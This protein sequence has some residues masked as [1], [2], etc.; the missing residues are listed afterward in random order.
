MKIFYLITKPEIGGA[1]KH[2]INLAE[3]YS[4]H[5][6]VLVISGGDNNEW[7]YRKC[8]D[9]G[10]DTIRFQSLVAPIKIV[11]DMIFL[12]SLTLYLRKEKPDV[13]HC[14]SSKAGFLGRIAGF[15]SK[16]KRVV[17]TVHGVSFQAEHSRLQRSIYL[18]AEYLAYR[19]SDKIICV[20][21]F[22]SAR[23]KQYIHDKSDKVIV[24]K[25][26]AK[27]IK[28]VTPPAKMK[29]TFGFL[30][31]MSPEKDPILLLNGFALFLKRVKEPNVELRIKGGGDL[32][33]DIMS[34]ISELNLNKYVVIEPMNDVIED[35]LGRVDILTLTSKYEGYP[36]VLLE[37]KAAGCYLIAS[38]VG[39]CSEI[40]TNTEIGYLFKPGSIEH[41]TMAMESA[42]HR[43]QTK[44]KR[45]PTHH[46]SSFNEFIS[47]VESCY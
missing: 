5:H 25:N 17:F 16:T 45:I 22:D 15:L 37:G 24:I 31:R 27:P 36:Y 47:A 40:I 34:K 43:V 26:V 39:G 29:I 35:Y 14:H 7:L 23:F 2:V 32:M 6:D 9:L 42:Y 44:E 4:N 13:L 11:Q 28:I 10:I 38:D 33:A 20:S 46:S 1:T 12:V 30:G 41:L 21:N 3:S 19:V 8:S 18:F